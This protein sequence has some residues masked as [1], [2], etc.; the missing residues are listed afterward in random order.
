MLR[1]KT[2]EMLTAGPF[3]LGSR[4]HETREVLGYVDTTDMEVTAYERNRSYTITHQKIGARIAAVFT[5]APE[6]EGT[7][8]DIEFT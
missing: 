3:G 1:M 7:R 2:I 8:V 6:K 5:F 4:W